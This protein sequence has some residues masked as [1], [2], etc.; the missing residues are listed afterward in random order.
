MVGEIRDN[1]TAEIAM[2]AALTGH[3]V[4]STLH[5]NDAASAINRLIDMGVPA[6]MMASGVTGVVAQ[7]LVRLVCPRCKHE[8]AITPFEAELLEQHGLT[9]DKLVEGRGCAAC[10]NTGYKGRMA[11]QEVL[12]VG[13]RSRPARADVAI[14]GGLPTSGEGARDADDVPRRARQGRAGQDHGEGS[15]AR[16]RG[17]LRTRMGGA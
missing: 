5:T 16:D 17:D 15:A 13:R 10:G 3:R 4:L 6:Y 7:R 8:R 1:E 11:V 14:D 12:E 9:A 2:R